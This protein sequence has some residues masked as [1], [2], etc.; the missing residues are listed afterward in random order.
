LREERLKV[1]KETDARAGEVRLKKRVRTDRQT[2]SVPVES[3]EV[4][5]ERRPVSRRAT[6][7]AVRAEEIRIPVR[8]DKVKV[9]KETVVREEVKVGK[10]KVSDT[11][12]VEADVRREE[13]VV[14]KEGR[15]RVR[16]TG[17]PRKS[18]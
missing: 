9:G 7:E 1:D 10:R 11:R 6:G 15:P 17:G 14:E 4:V 5:I 3:E 18:R 2:V 13:L 12:K 8:R 16:Q